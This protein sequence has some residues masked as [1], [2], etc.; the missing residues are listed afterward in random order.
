MELHVELTS[1]I[2]PSNTCPGKYFLIRDIARA[3]CSE[4]IGVVTDIPFG[5]SDIAARED[6]GDFDDLCDHVSLYRL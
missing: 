4:I 3:K 2:V 5:R 1:L 6:N